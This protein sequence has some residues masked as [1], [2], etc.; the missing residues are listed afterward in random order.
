MKYHI[1]LI[2]T[3]ACQWRW[4]CSYF[5]KTNLKHGGAIRGSTMT[6]VVRGKEISRYDD[7]VQ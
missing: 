2:T 3:R 6:A 4:C 1:M 5:C 7:M